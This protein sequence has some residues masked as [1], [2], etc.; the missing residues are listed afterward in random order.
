[1]ASMLLAP[2]LLVMA[3][4][5]FVPLGFTLGYS[6]YNN[7]FTLQAFS[8]LFASGLFLRVLRTSFE[9]SVTAAAVSVVLGYIVA[10]HLARQPPRRRALLMILVLVPFWMS[11][12]VK[13]FAF[14]IILGNQG[15]VN[16]ILMGLFGPG[17]RVSLMFNR[18][19]VVVAIAHNLLP[20]VVFP[21]LASLL[22]QDANLKRAA[23]LMG[24]GP[25]RIFWR[26]TLPLSMPGVIAA[27]L[28]TTVISMGSFVIP[29]LMGGRQDTMLANLVDYY[30][31]EALDWN[32]AAAAAVILLVLS[33][34]LLALLAKVRGGETVI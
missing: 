17:A 5:F 8:G 23:Q 22:T 13:S 24:A 9:I 12:L 11:I 25:A 14:T 29:S 28:M 33:L 16:A 18:I 27:G 34:V 32:T 1:M 4:A 30:T 21:V 31:R 6:V 26:I 7:G 3:L 15:V 2:V 19:G 20:Y 10:L